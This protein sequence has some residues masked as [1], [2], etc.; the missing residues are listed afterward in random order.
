MTAAVINV[1]INNDLLQV[2]LDRAQLCEVVR[3]ILGDAAV[4]RGEISV[5]VVD[6]PT[7]CRMHAKYLERDEPTDVLSFVY[8]RG[9]DSLEGEVIVSADTAEMTA[10][11]YDWTAEDELLLYVIHG[12]LHLVGY[13]DATPEQKTRM[14]HME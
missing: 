1:E 2:P 3:M 9:K 5:G 8:E 14:R 4:S 10:D 6:D 11:W 7:I 13:D 12:T